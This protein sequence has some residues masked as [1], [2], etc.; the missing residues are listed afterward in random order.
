MLLTHQLA[1]IKLLTTRRHIQRRVP[2]EEIHRLETHPDDL[3]GHN[4]EILDPR[5]M[6]QAELHEQHEIRVGDVFLAV[7]PRAH[8]LPAAGLVGVFPAR[9]EFAV[10]VAD[11]VEVVVGELGALVVVAFGVGEHFL[12]GRGVDF[13]GD[14]FVVDWVADGG[15]LDLEDAVG[16]VVDFEAGGCGH[17]GFVDGVADAVRVEVGAGHGDGFFVDEAVRVPVDGGVDAE[18]EDV[19]VVGGEDAGVDDG[20]PGDGDAGVDGLGAEDAGGADLVGELAGLVEHE[21]HDVFV[22]GDGDDGLNDEFAAAY[23][24]CAAGAVIGVFPAYAGILL[25]DA[26]DIFHW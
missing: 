14:G 3:T 10:V 19:L 1:L 9:V 23:H 18:G 12:E 8:A 21:G 6:L 20:A 24:G 22:V 16:V 13:V 26:D 15:V 2:L 11:G 4:R 17:E 25:V 7:R 5:A